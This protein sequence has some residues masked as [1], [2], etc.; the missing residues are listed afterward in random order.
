MTET[1]NS[2][3]DAS[4]DLPE[5]LDFAACE[6]LAA[7]F[8]AR[9]GAALHLRAGKVGFLGAL[10]AEILLRARLEWQADGTA[11]DLADPS[12]DFLRGLALLGIPR[13]AL[14]QEDSA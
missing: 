8:A 7:S 1:A 5:R 13:H 11:F 4:L 6:T 14:L 9:R 10:A 2:V 3:D 12:P